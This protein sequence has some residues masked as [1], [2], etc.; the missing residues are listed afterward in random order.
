L[1]KK[2]NDCIG[3]LDQAIVLDNC[4]DFERFLINF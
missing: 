1:R 4:D 3:K 2:D